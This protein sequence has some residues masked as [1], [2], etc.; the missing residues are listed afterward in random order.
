MRKAV[1]FTQCISITF[2]GCFTAAGLICLAAGYDVT[3]YSR[4]MCASVA[5][6]CVLISALA[7][8]KALPDE[9]LASI[10]CLPVI[11]PLSM[12]VGIM[13]LW[14]ANWRDV[15]IQIAVSIMGSGYLF[16]RYTGSA[17]LKVPCRVCCGLLVVPLSIAILSATLLADFGRVSVVQSL[18]SPEGSYE[19][20]LIDIDE[21]ALGGSTVVDV[22]DVSRSFDIGFARFDSVKRVYRTG[23]GAFET[24]EL[25]WQDDDTLLIDGQPYSFGGK[26]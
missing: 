13:L 23:W 1:F 15:F 24:M 17:M 11:L 14:N 20:M 4:A 10:R 9:R 19:A 25:S 26:E 6:I 22:K 16:R 2:M 21:G 12:C 7:Y 18:L 3:L 5:A 8:G